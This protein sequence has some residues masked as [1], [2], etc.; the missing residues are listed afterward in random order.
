M[1][2]L[3]WDGSLDRWLVK[4]TERRSVAGEAG[5]GAIN[6]AN[7]RSPRASPQR[8]AAAP[9]GRERSRYVRHGPRDEQGRSR[10]PIRSR[11]RREHGDERRAARPSASTGRREYCHRQPPRGRARSFA[12]RWFCSVVSSWQRRRLASAEAATGSAPC[13]EAN[14]RPAFRSVGD[15]VF[16]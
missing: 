7:V 1:V 11:P 14:I 13:C 3:A 15:R 8:S 6:A 16:R 12:V 2:R 9:A 10:H 5:W 4:P